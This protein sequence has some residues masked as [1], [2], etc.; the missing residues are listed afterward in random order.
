MLTKL[1]LARNQIGRGARPIDEVLTE[2]QDDVRMLLT[3]L[4]ELVHGVY[5]P[6]L[7]DRGLVAA[8]QART[9]RLPIVVMLHAPPELTGRRFGAD[10]EGATY[11]VVCEA[12]TNVV[13]HAGADA[14]N[15]ELAA[16][17]GYP[18]VEIRDDGAGFDRAD[19]GGRG[20]LGMRDRVLRRCRQ[21]PPRGVLC[22]DTTGSPDS[23]EVALVKVSDAINGEVP[24]ATTR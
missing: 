19:S 24:N 18:C 11:F 13:K 12:L 17:D 22:C 16:P 4:R 2:L 7:N 14:I 20:I 10:V 1:S 6:V 23:V 5:P 8:I 3:D 21:C 15:V 9:D